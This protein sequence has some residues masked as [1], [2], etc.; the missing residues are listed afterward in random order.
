M[1]DDWKIEHWPSRSWEQQVELDKQA[2]REG[3]WPRVVHMPTEMLTIEEIVE[4]YGIDQETIDKIK[5][6]QSD[7]RYYREHPE[8]LEPDKSNR[9]FSE[10]QLAIIKKMQEDIEDEEE[11]DPYNQQDTMIPENRQEERDKSG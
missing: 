8:E 9:V 2:I 6:V 4:K 5:A 10:E 11:D 7:M 1:E 3:K